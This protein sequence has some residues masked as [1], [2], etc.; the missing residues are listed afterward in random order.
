MPIIT[1]T[2]YV[3]ND[4]ELKKMEINRAF[5]MGK[6][7]VASLRNVMWKKAFQSFGL[8]ENIEGKESRTGTRYCK[9]MTAYGIS[10]FIKRKR[11]LL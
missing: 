10:R 4:E 2:E 5:R 1:L 7:Q 8:T 9:W 3:N 11:T 6:G